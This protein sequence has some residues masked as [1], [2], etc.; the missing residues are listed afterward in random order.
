MGQMLTATPHATSSES[1]SDAP[2]LLPG[3]ALPDSQL[4]ES[5]W[6]DPMRADPSSEFLAER[7]N[8]YLQ[9][10]IRIADLERACTA[11]C[12]IGWIPIESGNTA[13]AHALAKIEA[14]L[15]VWWPYVSKRAAT[16]DPA[17]ASDTPR[18][19]VREAA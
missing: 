15:R 11:T 2:A 14:L 4:E 7:V 9:R 16:A 6:A 17:T 18:E 12:G 5:P 10:R 19:T 13:A 8:Q 3:P 1:C